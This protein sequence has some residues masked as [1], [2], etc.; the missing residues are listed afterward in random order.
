MLLCY[1]IA[2]PFEGLSFQKLL[3][4]LGGVIFVFFILQG[5]MGLPALREKAWVKRVHFPINLA[6]SKMLY[7]PFFRPLIYITYIFTTNSKG[8]KSMGL[9]FVYLFTVSFFSF[10]LIFYINEA[11]IEPTGFYTYKWP[12]NG[13]YGIR[14]FLPMQGVSVGGHSL[15]ITFDGPEIDS[16]LRH[17]ILVPFQY[18]PEEQLVE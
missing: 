10:P 5:L 3:Y 9:T 16:T 12:D 15:R 4:G 11:E 7:G 2:L 6:V 18:Y 8:Y 14:A 1:L 13:Q 17:D